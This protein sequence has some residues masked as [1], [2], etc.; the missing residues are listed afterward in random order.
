MGWVLLH[1][2]LKL[3][4]PVSEQDDLGAWARHHLSAQPTSQ[5]CDEGKIGGKD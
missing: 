3:G 2:H 5:G 4:L 1:N